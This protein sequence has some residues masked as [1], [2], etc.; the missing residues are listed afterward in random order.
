MEFKIHSNVKLHEQSTRMILAK[1][2][3]LM[4]D[5]S[6]S[7]PTEHLPLNQSLLHFPKQKYL[8]IKLTLTVKIATE[9]YKKGLSLKSCDLLLLYDPI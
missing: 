7:S 9:K 3:V 6:S 1:Y 5:C 4:G 2:M 8:L